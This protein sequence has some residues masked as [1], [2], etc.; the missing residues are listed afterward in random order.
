[1]KQENTPNPGSDEAI[2]QG[3]LCPVLDNNHGLGVS[4]SDGQNLFWQ[5]CS[6][7]VHVFNVDKNED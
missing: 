1:M 5:S 6:C 4:T 7:P 3:C 2:E